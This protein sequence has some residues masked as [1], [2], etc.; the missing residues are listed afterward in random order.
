MSGIAYGV[1][2]SVCLCVL[3][4]EYVVV[5]SYVTVAERLCLWVSVFVC[6][7]VGACVRV[8]VRVYACV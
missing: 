8:C 3:N 2:V 6:A 1:C 4:Y 5:L 7:S